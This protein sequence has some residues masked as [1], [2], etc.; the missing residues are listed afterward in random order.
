MCA[1]WFKR[2]MVYYPYAMTSLFDKIF[3]VIHYAFALYV[4]ALGTKRQLPK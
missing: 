3:F 2:N 4:H 1:M